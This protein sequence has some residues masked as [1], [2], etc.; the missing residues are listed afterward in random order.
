MDKAHREQQAH[1]PNT[2]KFTVFRGQDL[3]H[4]YFNK[5]K[6]SKGGL[7]AFN[8]FHSTSRSREIS[9]IEFARQSNSD[10]IAV[11]FVMKIDPRL[12]E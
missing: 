4:E 6:K 3:S 11:L 10:L 7:M 8:K 12:C 9:I 5:M 2:D 1:R